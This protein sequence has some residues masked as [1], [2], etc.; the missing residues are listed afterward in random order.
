MDFA[1]KV[2]GYV[3]AIAGFLGLATQGEGGE[4]NKKEIEAS[5]DAKFL[6]WAKEFTR[7]SSEH[8]RK[9]MILEQQLN[10][11]TKK[12]TSKNIEMQKEAQSSPRVMAFVSFSMP[13]ELLIDLSLQLERVRGT[14]VIRG[15]PENSFKLLSEKI[16]LLREKGGSVP[17]LIDP[18][19]FETYN[20]QAVPSFVVFEG[21]KFDKIAG[22][23]SLGFALEQLVAQGET[24][25]A[26]ELLK[27]FWGRK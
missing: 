10:E 8:T 3:A 13:F 17:F 11:T 25:Y 27:T 24:T 16:L 21:S 6:Q 18:K 5:V 4:G 23:L 12:C 19:A 26:K 20:I 15:L 1:L 14:F 22:N 7:Q 2:A 9:N